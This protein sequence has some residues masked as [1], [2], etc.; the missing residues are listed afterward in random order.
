MP[1]HEPLWSDSVYPLTA[2]L[3]ALTGSSL[4]LSCARRVQLMGHVRGRGWLTGGAFS[5]GTGIWGMHFVAMLGY[6]SSDAG[7]RYDP[8]LTL[9]S[10]AVAVTFVGI[11]ML[12]VSRHTTRRSLL[13]SGLLAGAGIAAMHYLGMAALRMSGRRVFEGGTVALS[14]VIAVVAATA[15]LWATLRL[16]SRTARFAASL[17][18]AFAISGMHYT[19][20]MSMTSAGAAGAERAGGLSPISVVVPLTIGLTFIVFVVSFAVLMNPVGDLARELARQQVAPAQA[21]N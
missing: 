6:R 10:W 19:G 17:V 8:V 15:A 20:M 11:G 21:G 2:Y 14:V 9:L 7:I 16:T 3:I 5:L 13:F 4:G 12:L 1:H 18:M